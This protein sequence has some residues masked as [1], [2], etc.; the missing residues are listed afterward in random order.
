MCVVVV[1]VVSNETFLYGLTDPFRFIVDSEI[2]TTYA[3]LTSNW[4]KFF[5]RTKNRNRVLRPQLKTRDA[6]IHRAIWLAAR[7]LI[8]CPKFSLNRENIK[9]K[10]GYSLTY[11]KHSLVM[12]QKNES[13]WTR[14]NLNARLAASKSIH[15][16]NT[17]ENQQTRVLSPFGIRKKYRIHR[18]HRARRNALWNQMQMAK[19]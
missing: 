15:I 11:Q 10:I 17:P 1:V 13:L 2:Q 14:L 6:S 12:R 16:F 4:T 19:I 5:S 3:V 18:V 7:M 8:R 9:K